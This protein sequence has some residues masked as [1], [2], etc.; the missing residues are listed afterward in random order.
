LTSSPLVSSV[1]FTS[2]PLVWSVICKSSPLVLGV[3][4]S[5]SSLVSSVVFRK[6][7]VRPSTEFDRQ[8]SHNLGKNTLETSGE[9]VNYTR[10]EW[11]TCETT[12]ETSGELVNYTTAD[13][14]LSK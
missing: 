2:S 5:S 7:A 6:L 11:R 9:L 4:L 3:D 13:H 1:L 12:L 8:Q 10:N 14:V